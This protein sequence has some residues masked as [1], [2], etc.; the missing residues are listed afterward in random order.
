MAKTRALKINAHIGKSADVFK[1]ISPIC[2]MATIIYWSLKN[3]S[4][5]ARP[6]CIGVD[7][8]SHVIFYF[9]LIIEKGILKKLANLRVL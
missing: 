1:D 8:T 2:S 6:S 4:Q 5:Q 7:C 3:E 9:N